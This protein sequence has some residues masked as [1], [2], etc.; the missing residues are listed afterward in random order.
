MFVVKNPFRLRHLD[1][2]PPRCPLCGEDFQREIGFYYGA[3][4]ISHASTTVLAVI[5]H[6]VVFYFYGW[7]LLPNLLPITVIILVLFPV[8]FRSSRAIWINM[9]CSYDPRAIQNK[10]QAGGDFS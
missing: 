3:M 9:F 2:M 8:I 5:V 6:A 10:D 1:D 4:M 7:A